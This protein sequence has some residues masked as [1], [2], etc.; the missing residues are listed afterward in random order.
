VIAARA[1][2]EKKGAVRPAFPSTH[3]PDTARMQAIEAAL[4]ATPCGSG[5]LDGA[6]PQ[7]LEAY[8]LQ[9]CRGLAGQEPAR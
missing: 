6:G 7:M 1:S 4:R 8:R 3:P 9:M 2:N 5:G